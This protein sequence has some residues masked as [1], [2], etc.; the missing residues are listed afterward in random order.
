MNPLLKIGVRAARSAGNIIHRA[1][2]QGDGYGIH[3]KGHNDFV[4]DVDQKAEAE[5]IRTIQDSYRDHAFLGEETGR[6]GDSDYVWIIDPLDGTTNFI[7]GLPHF[8]VSLALQVKGELE[9]AVIYNPYNQ[10][11]YTA[12]R[13]M[14]AKLNDRK[15]RVSK[16]RKS[17]AA[18]LGTGTPYRK[19]QNVDA[20]MQTLK[21]IVESSSG[22]RRA[23]AASL[24]LAYV[25]AGRLDGFWEFGLKPWDVAAGI[26]LIRE[27]GGIVTDITTADDPLRSGNVLAGNP[28]IHAEMRMLLDTV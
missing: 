15:I 23:G 13:G 26:L 22:V 24:D 8:A 11:L 1:F 5:I 17:E 14:G 28:K 16:I 3:Q 10:E 27:A 20:Y 9:H 2:M 21:A 4:T 7:H 6:T 12:S 25:A 19:D 18:L